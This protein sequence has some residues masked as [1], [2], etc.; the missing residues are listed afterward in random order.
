[1]PDLTKTNSKQNILI[2]DDES[3]FL[4]LMKDILTAEGITPI[5]TDNSVN[6]L[7]ILDSQT[8]DILITDINMPEVTGIDLAIKARDKNPPANVIFIT[9]L[10]EIFEHYKSRLNFNDY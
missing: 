10:S 9:G 4:E 8:I 2:V 7:N 6:A 1:M 3:L 5:A